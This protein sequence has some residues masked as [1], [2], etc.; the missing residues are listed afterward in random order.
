M[1]GKMKAQVFYEP[2]NMKFEKVDIPEIND[3][4]VLIKVRACGI[5]GSDIAYYWGLSPLE[6]STG[7]GPLILGHEL[8]GEVVEVGRIPDKMGLFKPGDRVVAEPVQYCN[9]CE[10]CKR[11]MV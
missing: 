3:D 4:E 10:M 5:C 1:Q 7:K 9:T 6:T 8:A 2:E 11:G